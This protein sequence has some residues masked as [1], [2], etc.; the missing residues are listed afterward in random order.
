MLSQSERPLALL[1]AAR[2]IPLLTIERVE[3][4]VPLAKALVDG[5]L[6]TMEIALRTPAAPHAIR[7]IVRHVPAAIP[8]AGNV[9]TPRDLALAQEV[10]AHFALSP[11]SSP[12]LLD[13]AAA[14][15]LPFV[16]GIATPTELMQ[17]MSKGFHVVKFFP[18]VPFGGPAAL[19][20]MIAPFPHARFCP[21][22]G[23]SEAD[24]EAWFALPN[25]IAV[26]GQWLAPPEEIRAG[27]WAR[28]T[29]RAREAK[30]RIPT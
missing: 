18:S 17:V 14:G 4:A 25:V 13:A 24:Q 30:A 23:T 8:A 27:E 22:G 6:A 7:Q 1:A 12:A 26:G 29:Q 19:R 9:M 28:I 15:S 2:L 5:G 10:G 3:D 16:P 11:G 21:T 20:A